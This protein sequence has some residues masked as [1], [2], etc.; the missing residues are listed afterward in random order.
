[1]SRVASVTALI[2]RISGT[3]KHPI[4]RLTASRTALELVPISAGYARGAFAF[5]V[6]L[7]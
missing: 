1:M 5:G 3:P 2:E 7:I 4:N 6:D